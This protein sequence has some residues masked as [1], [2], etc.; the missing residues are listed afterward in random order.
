MITGWIF[1]AI[2]GVITI[3]LALL[4]PDPVDREMQ[5]LQERWKH[6]ARQETREG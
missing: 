4:D 3:V 6:R 2:A 5:D 1:L